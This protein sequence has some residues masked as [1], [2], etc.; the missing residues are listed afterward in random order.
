MSSVSISNQGINKKVIA[1]LTL[2]YFIILLW[3]IVFKCNQYQY[4]HIQIK[5]DLSILERIEQYPFKKWVDYYRNGYLS[6][7][8][9]IAFIFNFIC[10]LPFGTLMRFF[11]NKKWMIITLG[12]L[13]SVGVEV[14]QIISGWGGL[15]YTDI[16]MMILG[17]V[18]GIWIYDAL[19]PKMSEKLINGLATF[20]FV[21]GAPLAVLTI[22]KTIN[23]FPV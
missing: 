12:V 5:Q 3:V 1:G 16:A 7:L 18:A 14:F 21:F 11:V 20:L 9:I 23:N 22:I 19:R 15:E 8:E 17:V 13:F 4:L 2:V 6:A 10:L